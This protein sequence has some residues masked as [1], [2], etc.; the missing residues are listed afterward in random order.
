MLMARDYELARLR[1]SSISA[2]LINGV[3]TITGRGQPRRPDATVLDAR[4]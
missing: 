2:L 4:L 1:C 3:R